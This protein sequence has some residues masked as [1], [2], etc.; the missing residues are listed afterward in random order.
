MPHSDRQTQIGTSTTRA[1]AQAMNAGRV[2]SGAGEQLV[3]SIAMIQIENLYQKDPVWKLWA[4]SS[5]HP[6]GLAIRPNYGRRTL[7]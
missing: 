2:I 4:F 1:I 5:H 7:V 6:H 3:M